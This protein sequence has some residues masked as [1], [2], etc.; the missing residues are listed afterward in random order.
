MARSL[1]LPPA[2]RV[3]PAPLEG[4]LAAGRTASPLV[5]LV[6]LVV[7]LAI[8]CGGGTH[9]SLPTDA[10]VQLASLPLLALIVLQ[11]PRE[12][13]GRLYRPL[14]VAA[15]VL[16][17]PLLQL[18]PLPPEIWTRLPGRDG[19][20][21]T[22]RVAG[23][24]LPWQPLSLTP[25]ATRQ[26]FLSLLPAGAVFLGT[27]LL[28][29]RGRRAVSLVL[30]AG[31][32]ISVVLGL[33]QLM[34]GPYSP[35]RIYDVS[36]AEAVG[37]FANRNHQAALLYCLMPLTV[38]WA[39]G[40]MHGSRHPA[41]MLGIAVCV[42][43]YVAFM[44]GVGMTR[45]RAGLLLALAA[46]V[47]AF[48]MA[49]VAGRTGEAKN[50]QQ[51][52]RRVLRLVAVSTVLGVLAIVQFALARLL[53]RLETNLL[54]NYRFVIAATS[55]E[56]AKAFF[57]F[58]SGFGTFV[59]VYAMFETTDALRNAYVNH[60][61]ND[62]LELVIEGGVA[63]ILVMVLFLVWFVP[64]AWR[65]WQPRNARGRRPL[66]LALARSA[67]FIILLLFAH[68]AVDYPMRTTTIMVLFGF[69]CALLVPPLREEPYEEREERGS[70]RSRRRGMPRHH[71][72]GSPP[73]HARA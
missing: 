14:I 37:F 53:P 63:A 36:A 61:H 46:S 4:L 59:P 16:L 42:C 9:Q 56:A 70:G 24:A 7:G 52:Q 5:W 51:R 73:R 6:P 68:S 21:E 23:I 69:A 50:R 64:A 54:D 43:A 27:L 17:V 71:H 32:M 60:A 31:G 3:L 39:I 67:T 1:S 47:G 45:S 72:H 38:A 26:M 48:A 44:L 22:Y 30:L 2:S 57:P 19:I 15:A 11:F 41:R 58:G 55:A 12:A 28:S 18:V 49:F 10:L 65:A 34:Q 62:W 40:L 8:A 35:L 20:A 13:I 66:D 25:L 33:G 29:A